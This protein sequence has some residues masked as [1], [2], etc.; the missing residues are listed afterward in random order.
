MS[1]LRLQKLIDS[2]KICYYHNKPIVLKSFDTKVNGYIEIITEYDEEPTVF[3]K[4][5]EEK[6]TFFLDAIKHIKVM[7]DEEEQFDTQKNS[8]SIPARQNAQLPSLYV[9]TKEIMNKLA[10]KL[11]EDIDK[12]REDSAYTT[13]AKQVCN[14]VNTILNIAKVQMQMQKEF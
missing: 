14:N 13:Q 10:S 4:E 9:E 12:V 6:L 5:N 7:Q 8:S 1:L 3:V 2:G 11:L